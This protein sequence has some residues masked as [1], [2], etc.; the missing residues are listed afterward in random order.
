MNDIKLICNQ[1]IKRL[2][3][4]QQK[5]GKTGE[6]QRIYGLKSFEIF[7]VK[8]CRG[9]LVFSIDFNNPKF[10]QFEVIESEPPM[11]P[12]QLYNYWRL[13]YE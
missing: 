10:S 1:N 12:E 4:F 5:I 7:D 2:Y 3:R 11:E 9:S 13:L 8:L 6:T